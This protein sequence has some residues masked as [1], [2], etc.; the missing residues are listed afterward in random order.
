MFNIKLPTHAIY[1]ISV[2]LFWNMQQKNWYRCWRHIQSGRAR[3]GVCVR[4]GGGR[5]K[6]KTDHAKSCRERGKSPFFSYSIT[7]TKFRVKKTVFVIWNAWPV[8]MA[9]D[10][11][12]NG[13][14]VNKINITSMT[15]V[16]RENN[17]SN[18][19]L[20]FNFVCVCLVFFLSSIHNSGCFFS[21]SSCWCDA[22][23]LIKKQIFHK[24]F[25]AFVEYICSCSLAKY[26]TTSNTPRTKKK[27]N[28]Q[29]KRNEK[30]ER[31]TE[32]ER[33]SGF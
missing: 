25:V 22:F 10:E 21:S 11:R 17:I 24:F 18:I 12:C 28:M 6:P 13:V 8:W 26:M 23:Y 1:S 14:R 3:E 27:T 30:N 20:A 5:A 7:E 31:N 4:R 33:E 19:F 29:K 32:G 2:Y 15:H 16:D 9:P